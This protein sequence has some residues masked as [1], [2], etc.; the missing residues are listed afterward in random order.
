M[1]HSP[2]SPVAITAYQCVSAGGD[3]IETLLHRLMANQSCLQPLQLFELPFTTVVGEILSPLPDIRPELKAYDCRNARLAL[4]ALNQGRFRQY[5]EQAIA[6]YGYQRIAVIL[7]TST[8]GIYD[9]ENAYVALLRDGIMPPDFSFLTTH[10]AQATAEFLKLELNL[11]GPCY[12]VSTACSSSAKALGVGQR[13]IASNVCDAVLVA[14]V[15][16]LCRL[17]LRGFQSLQ[18]ISPTHCRPMD[19]DRCGINIGE[20]AALLLLERLHTG[21]AE[22]PRLLSVGESSDAHHMAAPHP[23][24]LGAALAMANALQLAKCGVDDIDY[25][26]LHATASLMNDLSEAKAVFRLFPKPP[27]CSGV[28]GLIGH[29][30][31][32][33]G[34]IEVVVSLLALE[35]SFL[36]GTCG[37]RQIDP[38]LHLQVIAEPVVNHT[39]KRVLSNALGFGGNNAS[40]LLELP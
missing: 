34:A 19:K 36:P 38:Q 39:L 10:T 30:L 15:D 5:V 17:T 12:A 8:S 4:K 32:A 29:T 25:V 21:N 6:Q 24:G 27:P 37:L 26:N 2:L 7:G 33:A 14:G 40:V 1:T 16:S 23:E 3:D 31:G 20:G 11:N 22:C 9:T 13:L 18:L 35:H 28:K